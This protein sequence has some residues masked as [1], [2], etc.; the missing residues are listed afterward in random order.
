MTPPARVYRPLRRSWDT[1]LARIF[2]WAIWG[3]LV[4]AAFSFVARNG[5]SVPY[6]DEWSLVPAVAGQQPLTFEFLWAQHNEHRIPLPKLILVG[7]TRLCRA[8]FRAGLL[9]IVAAQSALAAVLILAVTKLRG[10]TIYADAFFP[11]ALL[12][13]GHHAN[14]ES[15]FQIGFVLSEVLACTLLLLIACTRRLST[16]GGVVAAGM[17]LVALPY[18]GAQGVALVPALALWMVFSAAAL[19]K[20]GAV[21]CALWHYSS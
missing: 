11:L 14:F 4:S 17:C 20:K 12:H 13:M 6:W 2:V 10:R 9:A 1:S 3:L 19:W 21:R 16:V 5:S 15:S 7:L 8:D 18:L